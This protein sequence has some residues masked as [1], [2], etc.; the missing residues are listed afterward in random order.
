[1]PYL[2]SA[3]TEC[4]QKNIS[5]IKP[6]AQ[7]IPFGTPSSFDYLLHEDIFVSPF[8]ENGTTKRIV[9]PGDSNIQWSYWFNVSRVFHGGN[10]IS[11]FEC[12]YNEFTVFVKSGSIL[13]LRIENELLS[14]GTKHSKD[15][16]TLLI[17]RPQ[18]GQ[19]IKNV[20][21]FQ[22]KGY[23]VNYNYDSNNKSMNISLSAHQTNRYIIALRGVNLKRLQHARL[24]TRV[25]ESFNIL[26]IKTANQFWLET[27]SLASVFKSSENG[28][29]LFIKINSIPK[30]GIR[31]ILEGLETF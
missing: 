4:F 1:V 3:G 21:E 9:F 31:L 11:N 17:T 29:L 26:E 23:Q 22:S 16:I 13:P 8:V 18:H 30:Y 12:P 24:F 28:G 5:V 15:Y 2:L 6:L 27:N 10:I 20:H 14:L 25:D 7:P 19:V